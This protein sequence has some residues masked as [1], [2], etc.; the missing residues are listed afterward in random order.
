MLVT[1]L[2]HWKNRQHNDSVTNILHRSPSWN[3]QHN[4]VTNIT[5][6]RCHHFWYCI[7]S[8]KWILIVK[9]NCKVSNVEHEWVIISSLIGMTLYYH[10][11]LTRFE[12]GSL[13]SRMA[14]FMIFHE[15]SW[16]LEIFG[17]NF[18][19]SHSK[20]TSYK[21]KISIWSFWTKRLTKFWPWLDFFT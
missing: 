4:V 9:V 5:T 12:T 8:I 13:L 19:L 6:S 10:K 1:E 11:S 17:I 21:K 15:L 2:I 18:E 7:F 20:T 3:H 14:L 16:F